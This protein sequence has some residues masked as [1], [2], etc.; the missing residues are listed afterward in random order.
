MFRTLQSKATKI[1]L[2]FIKLRINDFGNIFLYLRALNNNMITVN[3]TYCHTDY[4]KS[5][6]LFCI[7][8]TLLKI[9]LCDKI[10]DKKIKSQLRVNH[11]LNTGCI[12]SFGTAKYFIEYALLEK[13]FKDQKLLFFK[14]KVRFRSI[15]S[16]RGN[17]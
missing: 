12:K 3:V 13:Y 1:I 16:R 17:H 6:Y 9:S 4:K 7:C 5:Y 15:T 10:S 8:R 2:I 11:L 14:R